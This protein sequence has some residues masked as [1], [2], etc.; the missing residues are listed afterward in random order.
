VIIIGHVP[1][2]TTDGEP[3]F[4]PFCY[5]KYTKLVKS[6]SNTILSQYYGHVNKDFAYIQATTP[7]SKEKV[8]PV[9]KNTIG[10]KK[11][12]KALFHSILFTGPSIVPHY[13]PGFRYGILKYENS[14]YLDEHLQYYSNLKLQN[15]QKSAFSFIES[16]STKNFGLNSLQIHDWTLLSTQSLK[17]DMDQYLECGY[18]HFMES[19]VAVQNLFVGL[20][21]FAFI[22]GFAGLF[23]WIKLR[24]SFRYVQLE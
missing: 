19:N 9:T 16:C 15:S 14:W 6:Y 4:K 18:I 17:F 10:K 5:Q 7:K 8:I 24:P 23:V 21:I 3:L 2:V 11:F 13:N 20:W 12:K 1:P 22:C